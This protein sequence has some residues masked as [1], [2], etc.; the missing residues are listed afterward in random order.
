MKNLGYFF[1]LALLFSAIVFAPGCD[2]IK[3]NV[4]GCSSCNH[5]HGPKNPKEEVASEAGVQSDVPTVSK[6][7]QGEVLLSSGKKSLLTKPEFEEYCSAICEMEPQYKQILEAIPE[8]KVQLFKDLAT[9]KVI[10]EWANKK[11]LT[12]KEEFKKKS[13]IQREN[14]D[15]ALAMQEFY[16]YLQENHLNFSQEELKK[17]YQDEKTK[18]PA[19]QQPP[20]L[21]QEEGTLAKGVKFDKED[22]AKAFLEKVKNQD[23]N[24]DEVA[25]KENKKVEDFGVVNEQSYALD[26]KLRDKI[27]E[28]KKLPAVVEVKGDEENEYWVVKANSKQKAKYAPFDKVKDSVKQ[29][30]M[31]AKGQKISEKVLEKIEKEL[32]IEKNAKSLE[33]EI[34][35][36]KAEANKKNAEAFKKQEEKKAKSPEAKEPNAQ[37]NLTAKQVQG[38]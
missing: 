2:W 15:R 11:G 30:M 26:T 6:E 8:S 21:E 13:K 38:A 32:G 28:L 9:Q 34:K 7:A 5:D 35:Q 36:A 17:F 18:N 27:L 12:E 24:L 31:Q 16:K 4:G 10:E 29:V 25:K 23:L 22:Q 14:I 33:E 1:S 19:F 3:K 20:F 37:A